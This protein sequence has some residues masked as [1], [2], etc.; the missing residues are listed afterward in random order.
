MQSSNSS[1]TEIKDR[2]NVV[3]FISSFIPLKKAGANYKA[4]CPFHHEKSA[5]LMVS[6]SKQIWHCF[7]CGEGGD[8]FTFIMK[9]ENL[10]FGEAL[11][12]LASRAGIELPKFSGENEQE[13]Q[14]KKRILAVNEQAARFYNEVLKK[15]PAAGFARQYL[16]RRGLSEETI[17]EWQI[18][19]APQ[20]A[21]VLEGVL[22]KKDFK[23]QELLDAGLLARSE[24]GLYDRFFGRI[25]FPI[26]NYSGDIVG[27]TA[28]IL[29]DTAKAAKYVNSPE[30]LVYNKSRVVF[31]LYQ[32]KQAIRKEDCAIVV[33]GNMDVIACHQ[34]GFKNA[35]G[36][37]GTAF[38]IDQL[39]TLARLTKKLKFAF[40]TDA[41]GI[42]A[43]RRALDM[44][45][46]L[47][48]SVYIARIEGAKD[49][50]ELI[51]KD[52]ELF[53]KAI[54][55]A[56]LYLDYFF[57]KAFVNYDPRSVE[58]K[59]KIAADLIPMIRQLT[60]PLE[61]AHYV[62]LL[63]QRL[64]VPEKSLYEVLAKD[65]QRKA[66]ET[67]VAEQA[68]PEPLVKNRSYHLERKILGYAMFDPT[69]RI[70]IAERISPDDFKNEEIRKVY[71]K[72]ISENPLDLEKFTDTLKQ[73][74]GD[75]YAELAKLTHFVIES[76]YTQVEDSLA[77]EREFN[78]IL[79]EFKTNNT[80]I[81]MKDLIT[82]MV[83]AEQ[84][85]DKQKLAELNQRF[86]D[87]SKN[88][89]ED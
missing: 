44:A 76:E 43:T 82:E 53:R 21:N 67:V 84:K 72:L 16:V 24:R 57:E 42:N 30:T 52:P 65:Q 71:E 23:Q 12:I 60:D 88:L 61:I 22:A 75:N 2:I 78:Q 25:T 47:G 54:D 49:P 59:K 29:D 36:S 15:L 8:I 81:Q 9:Y 74:L 41:A 33:E 56:P 86:S 70:Y 46:R 48:F 64:A 79:N 66:V 27:F 7:G 68:T 39:T 17:N 77:F 31:G 34:A 50:D 51:K 62:R 18:G 89:R 85:N 83:L 37:S 63:S 11:K 35:V 28:R 14:Y 4:A 32:A 19:F 26:R 69:L 80:K 55:E 1:I 45:L 3:D 10:D 58:Q 5:S 38:T 40:D 73:E 6:P 13:N 20:E 87:L